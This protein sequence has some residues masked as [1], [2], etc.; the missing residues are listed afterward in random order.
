MRAQEAQSEGPRRADDSLLAGAA[1]RGPDNLGGPEGNQ[2]FLGFIE[3][4]ANARPH[5]DQEG[6][7]VGEVLAEEK[8]R[9]LALPEYRPS[10]DEILPV[11]IDPYGYVR[12]DKNRYAVPRPRGSTITLVASESTVRLKDGLIEVAQYPRSY[13]RKERIGRVLPTTEKK[14]TTEAHT[15]R[16]QLR[17]IA[18]AIDALYER[19]LDL[20]H[21][22]GSVTVRAHRI[23]QNYGPVL[24]REAVEQMVEKNLV[25]LGALESACDQLLKS[26]RSRAPVQLNLGAHVPDRDMERTALEVFDER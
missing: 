7:T 16:G 11:S 5:P 2:Q 15:V 22:I 3:H 8:G 18:P 26:K 13:G 14:P 1:L 4:V 25:D 10:T 12:F 17:A 24:F 21:N 6:R 20:G 23:A 19:W 9:L